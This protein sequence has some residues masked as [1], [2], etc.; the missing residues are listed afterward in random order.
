[1]R[2]LPSSSSTRTPRGSMRR[3]S[4]ASV[5]RP[6]SPSAPASST[7][8]GPA[9]TTT[10]VS[11][12]ALLVGVGRA[13]GRLVGQE[14]PAPD[15]QRVLDRLE[16]RRQIGPRLA[17]VRV[18]RARRHHQVV[19]RELAVVEHDPPRGRLDA[20]D[21]G[22]QHARV[23]LLAQRGA[24]RHGDVTGRQ[25]RGGD[26]VQQR[27]KQV[28]VPAVDQRHRDGR[29]RQPARGRQA[30]EA[31]ANDDHVGTVGGGAHRGCV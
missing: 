23:G 21:I 6:I 10:K 4:C 20:L 8:V 19:V 28:M 1:M 16:A 18:G 29:A 5:C 15:L 24:D 30:A 17:E 25:R 9:P 11:Q 31:A 26:L 3:K 22:Q 7:P 14:H 2:S 13:L 27:L 12:P